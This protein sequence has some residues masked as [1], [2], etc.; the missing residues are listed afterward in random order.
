MRD[1]TIEMPTD[2]VVQNAES[3]A[4]HAENVA[5][6]PELY[7]PETLRRIRWGEIFPRRNIFSGGGN[8]NRRDGGLMTSLPRGFAG[9]AYDTHSGAGDRR[10]EERSRRAAPRGTYVAAEHA[11]VQCVGAAHDLSALRLYERRTA[12][13]A[14]DRRAALAGGS[15]AEAGEC[16][17]AGDEFN[18]EVTLCAL[19][20]TASSKGYGRLKLP[21]MSIFANR[22]HTV[23]IS[24]RLPSA[25]RAAAMP[26]MREVC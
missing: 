14:A 15:G 16:L 22:D 1:V 5:R 17:R 2:R 23:R 11:A 8:W 9:H 20:G 26:S 3:Y 13:R 18:G 19:P 24:S 21:H 4:Y 10:S 7:Q 12:Y 25:F 6:T